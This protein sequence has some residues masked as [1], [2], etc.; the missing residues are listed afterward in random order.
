MDF[1][2]FFFFRVSKVQI[3]LKKYIYFSRKEKIMQLRITKSEELFGGINALP[4]EDL[5]QLPPVW[6]HPVYEQ[7]PQMQ[8]ATT[9]GGLSH[10]VN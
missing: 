5:M 7:P 3:S 10:S 4:Y 2:E 9:Y 1:I 8:P 6:N